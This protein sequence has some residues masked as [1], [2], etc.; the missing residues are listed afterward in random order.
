MLNTILDV[1][2]PTVLDHARR[3]RH[4][5]PLDNADGHASLS[6]LC[7]DT[8]EFWLIVRDG[9]VA[10]AAFFTDGCGPSLASGSMAACLAEGIAVEDVMDL[11]Q[12]DVLKALGGLPP[13]VEHCARLAA[14]SLKAACEDFWRRQQK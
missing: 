9:R 2:S 8:M 5:G 3:P 4:V 6:G 11:S 13:E 7:G 1:F 12:K 10:R 14:E